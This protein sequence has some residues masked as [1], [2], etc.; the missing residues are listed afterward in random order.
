MVEILTS[1]SK[2]CITVSSLKGNSI[3]I[4]E[5]LNSSDYNYVER[6]TRDNVQKIED[7]WNECSTILLGTSTYQ[8]SDDNEPKFPTQLRK[9][10]K[11]LENLSGKT[12]I[13]FGSGRGDYP[14]FGGGLDYLETMLSKKNEVRL[15]YKFEGY[16]RVRQKD[17]FKQKVEEI[18]NENHEI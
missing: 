4:L 6:I 14:M 1:I 12:I 17:E 7:L 8:R 16:P 2:V 5:S 18:L 10:K 3:G 9:M 13:L 11:A 15:V